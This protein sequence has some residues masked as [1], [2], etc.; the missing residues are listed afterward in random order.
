MRT[1][2]K[3]LLAQIDAKQK[4]WKGKEMPAAVG[5][6]IDALATEASELQAEIDVEDAREAKLATLREA[7][8]RIVDPLMPPEDASEGTKSAGKVVGYV[9]TGDLVAASKGLRDFLTAGLPKTALPSP[10]FPRRCGRRI[11]P[12]T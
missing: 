3:S 10:R 8:K 12:G 11:G 4:E 7:G 1:K 9:T 5:T 2:F 6:E